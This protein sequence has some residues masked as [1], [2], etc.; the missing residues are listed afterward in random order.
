[1]WLSCGSY[2]VYVA[3]TGSM[4]LLRDLCDCFMGSMWLVWDLCGCYGVYVAITWSVWLLRD[5]CGCYGVYVAITW[6]VWLLRD[7]CGCYG[8]YVAFTWSVWLLWDLC[9]CYRI[10]IYMYVAVTCSCYRRYVAVMGSMSSSILWKLPCVTFTGQIYLTVWQAKSKCT[11][12]DAYDR[13]CRQRIKK[14]ESECFS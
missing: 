10:Y 13:M 7:L 5:L 14:V 12:S 2:R 9:G 3:V 8:V 1:M 4:C 6:S 11:Q